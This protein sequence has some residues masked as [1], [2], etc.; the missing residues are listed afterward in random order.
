MLFIDQ[1]SVQALK[2]RHIHTCRSAATE[3]AQRA[4]KR[5]TRRSPAMPA[6]TPEELNH[7]AVDA[8]WRAA[9]GVV[10]DNFNAA[11]RLP[12]QVYDFLLPISASTCQGMFST[13]MM[14]AGAMPALSNGASVRLWNQKP[15]PLALMVLRM[16][17]PQRGKSRLFQAVELLFETAD[18]FVAKRSKEYADELAA[19][20]V[21]P[22][23]GAGPPELQ[24]TTKSVSLQ[25]F[26]MTEF[27]YRCSVEFRGR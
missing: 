14:F 15:S 27:F 17:P 2:H 7:K 1:A 24:V 13:V 21:P 19:K 11:E 20:L 25:S 4:H 18:D 10:T 5:P 23:E 6:S 8:L 12:K 9:L 16:A 26:T 22:V 3:R